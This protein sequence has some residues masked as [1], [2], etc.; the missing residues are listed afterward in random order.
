MTN[1]TLWVIP[2]MQVCI[3]YKQIGV[4]V[5]CRRLGQRLLRP[6]TVVHKFVNQLVP[7][8]RNYRSSNYP[9]PYT[10]TSPSFNSEP[11]YSMYT[12]N[13]RTFYSM[14]GLKHHIDLII[15]NTVTT[16]LVFKLYVKNTCTFTDCYKRS[17]KMKSAYPLS[18][19]LRSPIYLMCSCF[20]F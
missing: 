6:H 3:I 7:I 13:S 19:M 1:Q 10:K 17:R 4:P 20:F 12:V 15:L 9:R 18:S 8:S 11:L 16:C 2:S 5:D 14:H